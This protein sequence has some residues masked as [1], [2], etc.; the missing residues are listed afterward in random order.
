MYAA[1]LRATNCLG[2]GGSMTF[3]GRIDRRYCRPACRT[4][5]YRN[6]LR[7][8]QIEH[9][10]TAV[11]RWAIGRLPE[12]YIALTTLGRVQGNVTVLARQMECEE[13][14]VRAWLLRL[15]ELGDL[16][17]VV[18]PPDPEI[19]LRSEADRL[20][21]GL[22]EA[23][24]QRNEL[25]E[26]LRDHKAQAAAEIAKL[27][28]ELE[29]MHQQLDERAALIS[30][31]AHETTALK[32]DEL[33]ARQKIKELQAQLSHDQAEL[34]HLK[35]ELSVV[36]SD[37]QSVAN[38]LKTVEQE[39]TA[40]IN[41][42]AQVETE[43]VVLREAAK[44][45]ARTLAQRAQ[46][47]EAVQRSQH[48]A[49][50]EVRAAIGKGPSAAAIAARERMD[51]QVARI[52]Q[53]VC[54]AFLADAKKAGHG[55]TI[56][57]WLSRHS[58]KI[59]EAA[60]Y[61]TRVT[62]TTRM[63]QEKPIPI[64][65]AAQDAYEQTIGWYCSDRPSDPAGFSQWFQDSKHKEFLIVLATAIITALDARSSTDTAPA[66]QIQLAHNP[67]QASRTKPNRSAVAPRLAS[68]PVEPSDAPPSTPRE[69]QIP[70]TNRNDALASLMRDKVQLL[71]MLAEYQE[72]RLEEVTGQLLEPF[73]EAILA[74]ISRQSAHAAR[75]EY[76][77]RPHGLSFDAAQLDW[78]IEGELLDPRS[79][80]VLFGEVV[81]QIEQLKAAVAKV[82]P[83]RKPW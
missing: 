32:A 10:P 11:P 5:A 52:R 30:K 44:Q 63:G 74:A 45:P 73:N 82:K 46:P 15:R 37:A 4:L 43:L 1:S 54:L 47:A 67:S 9:G 50:T 64:A 72:E 81:D 25:D 28:K 36:K 27:R 66:S 29:S 13:A 21:A 79:E 58:V 33:H 65:K 16:T 60:Q 22:D 59:H 55:E 39:R 69:L 77:F 78:V 62:L 38:K 41:G 26:E 7:T 19:R 17:P 2:C 42:K 40:L 48:G 18:P 24:A 8:R 75:R 71:H 51:E 23:L 56:E 57:H 80:E 49:T 53:M 61:L 76:Y 6:R 83:K 34:S 35:Q 12:L 14:S 68:S 3:G 31:T 70:R 20:R